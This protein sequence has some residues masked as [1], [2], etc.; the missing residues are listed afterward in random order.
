MDCFAWDFIAEASEETQ[1][2][3]NAAGAQALWFFLSLLVGQSNSEKG[4]FVFSTRPITQLGCYSTYEKAR[5][6]LTQVWAELEVERV[7]SRL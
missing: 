5:S 3:E 4:P 7:C 2:A 1:L 6:L